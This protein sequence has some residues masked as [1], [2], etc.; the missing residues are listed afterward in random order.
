MKLIPSFDLWPEGNE[1]HALFVSS[2]EKLIDELLPQADLA[3]LESSLPLVSWSRLKEGGN[4][5]SVS[6]VCHGEYSHGTGRFLSDALSRQLIP[7]QLLELAGT[8]SMSFFFDEDRQRE[9]LI[10]ERWVI[11]SDPKTANLIASKLPSFTQMLR[12][13]LLT[14]FRMRHFLSLRPELVEPSSEVK[15]HLST[16]EEMHRIL[17]RLSAEKTLSEIREYLAPVHRK[18][19]KIFDR[20]LFEEIKPCMAIYD[21]TFLGK[22]KMQFLARLIAYHAYFKK[23]LSFA[24][25]QENRPMIMKVFRGKQTFG[26]LIGTRL[27]GES[28]LLRK[29]HLIEAIQSCLP[30]V[31]E[32]PGS[33]F[34]DQSTEQQP[35]LY[36]EIQKGDRC[37][38]SRD[39]LFP[40]RARLIHELKERIQ[41]VPNSLFMLRND[42]DHLRHIMALS[43]ELKRIKDVPQV[44]I[45]FEEQS[46]DEI[47][48]SVVLLRVLKPG[49]TPL[50]ET[51]SYLPFKIDFRELRS[52]GSLRGKYIKEAAIFKVSM[53][54]KRFF[55]KDRSLDLPKA[56]QELLS[57]LIEK[58]GALRDYNGG[59]LS[60]QLETLQKLKLLLGPISQ[61]YAF[62]LENFFFSLEPLS[63][64]ATMH[65]GLLKTGF[66]LLLELVE[67]QKTCRIVR[68]AEGMAAGMVVSTP[69]EK[70]MLFSFLTTAKGIFREMVYSLSHI[71][72]LFCLM[73]FYSGPK[74]AALEQ[75]LEQAYMPQPHL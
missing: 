70:E 39:D 21:E 13:T 44:V 61:E 15:N 72:D 68:V 27:L 48:F 22:R 5:F 71:Q 7:G 2:V 19:P 55:R 75:L 54:K 65:P 14:I 53:S 49:M 30:N 26:L 17:H 66:A 32:I 51:L 16:F 6:V 23:H 25:E 43:R 45:S 9:Y 20:D 38:F 40:L 24:S 35:I 60:K 41:N 74:Q 18:R 42:E 3:S 57:E 69:Q 46:L 10:N 64:Q 73:I 37:P 58:F 4:T 33:F 8:R 31:K 62:P 47:S 67:Q 52:L 12:L 11:A 36:I 1:G 63:A 50:K 56:R 28:E 29:H 34:M 59:L